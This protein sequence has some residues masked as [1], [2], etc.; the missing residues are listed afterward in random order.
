MGTGLKHGAKGGEHMNNSKNSNTSNNSNASNKATQPMAVNSTNPALINN[1]KD[2]QNPEQRQP[3]EPE[4]KHPAAPEQPMTD[5]VKARTGAVHP[6]DKA[7]ANEEKAGGLRGETMSHG[8]DT[9][10]PTRITPDE[11]E[12]FNGIANGATNFESL[13]TTEDDGVGKVWKKL[14][15]TY[16]LDK[17]KR[18]RYVSETGTIEEVQAAS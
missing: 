13:S 4:Q 12:E 16:G 14:A 9:T 3:N 6:R 18:Y 8:K 1:P 17:D 5:Q 15:K 11:A 10:L 7:V 2:V